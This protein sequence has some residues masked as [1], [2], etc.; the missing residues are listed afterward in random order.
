MLVFDA[1]KELEA[2]VVLS[3]LELKI[4]NVGLDGVIKTN[5]QIADLVGTNTDSVKATRVRMKREKGIHIF[6]RRETPVRDQ[7]IFHLLNGASTIGELADKINV[8]NASIRVALGKIRRNG[9]IISLERAPRS[10]K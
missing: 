3:P 4:V 10:E 9:I 2:S 7:I 5:R 8:S 1:M 6:V